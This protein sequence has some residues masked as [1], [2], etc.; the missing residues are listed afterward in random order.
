MEKRPQGTTLP[1]SRQETEERQ[2]KR[3]NQQQEYLENEIQDV[4]TLYDSSPV[5]NQSILDHY[6]N[7]GGTGEGIR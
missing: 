1:S 5:C 6:G 3:R 4:R 7:N 2:V